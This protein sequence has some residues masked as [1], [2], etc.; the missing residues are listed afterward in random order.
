MEKPACFSR[1]ANDMVSDTNPNNR[2]HKRNGTSQEEVWE[3][4]IP[5]RI[6]AEVHVLV[7][8]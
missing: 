1:E 3:G 4:E 2:L 5:W 6:E 8:H 7:K